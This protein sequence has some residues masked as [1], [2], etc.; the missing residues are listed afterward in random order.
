MADAPNM[1]ADANGETPE[2]IQARMRELMRGMPNTTENLNR[3]M[4]AIAVEN[5]GGME[6]MAPLPINLEGPAQEAPTAQPQR[7]QAQGSGSLPLPPPPPPGPPDNT[8]PT[9]PVQAP[10]PEERFAG[11][12]QSRGTVDRILSM[13]PGLGGSANAATPPG[14]APIPERSMESNSTQLQRL[15]GINSPNE[16]DL[17][18]TPSDPGRGAGAASV[19]SSLGVGAPAPGPTDDPALTDGLPTDAP[20]PP[21][22]GSAG[23]RDMGDRLRSGNLGRDEAATVAGVLGFGGGGTRAMPAPTRPLGPSSPLPP[24]PNGQVTMPVKANVVPNAPP[25]PVRPVTPPAPA[26]P[27]PPATVDVSPEMVSGVLRQ[28]LGRAGANQPVRP[29]V[30]A[31]EIQGMIANMPARPPMPRVPSNAAGATPGAHVAR[32][33]VPQ[34]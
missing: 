4:Q 29:G 5:R 20:M 13:I 24:R 25:G 19:R 16:R 14:E 23:L 28:L 10:P 8:L 1:V 34:G 11:A 6:G 27:P 32:Q 7:R 15:L 26:A 18:T 12:A 21:R 3:A 31:D 9:P 17:P 30:I 2:S 33:R 22:G